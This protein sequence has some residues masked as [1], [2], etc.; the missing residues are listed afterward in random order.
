M[1]ILTFKTF[2]LFAFLSFI[3][4]INFAADKTNKQTFNIISALLLSLRKPCRIFKHYCN[5]QP[6]KHGQPV[7][8]I[9]KKES[10]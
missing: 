3:A 9:L 4:N 5:S 7:M 2:T 1:A 8:R 6:V 10:F